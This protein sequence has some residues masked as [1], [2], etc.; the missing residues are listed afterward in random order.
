[1]PRNLRTRLRIGTCAAL[2]VAALIAPAAPVAASGSGMGCQPGRSNDQLR[3][4]DWSGDVS[5]LGGGLYA[6]IFDYSPWVEPGVGGTSAWVM[7]AAGNDPGVY[8][9]IGWIEWAYGTR[10]T[11]TQI[12]YIQNGTHYYSNHNAPPLPV[13]GTYYYTVNYN[14]YAATYPF[15]YYA[16]N[17]LINQDGWLIADGTLKMGEVAGEIHSLASQMPGGWA[18]PS[19]TFTDAHY[20]WPRGSTGSWKPMNPTTGGT[21]SFTNRAVYNNGTAT[22]INDKACPN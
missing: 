3:Y 16:N 18:G 6:Q 19:E 20:W 5:G 21:P 4:G 22:A 17:Q 1:M 12:G 9:Q 8:A 7:L 10:Y 13:G 14:P 11:F 2:A 15:S